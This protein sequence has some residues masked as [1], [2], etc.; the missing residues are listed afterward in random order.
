MISIS[1]G[2]GDAEEAS[3]CGLILFIP[4]WDEKLKDVTQVEAVL[5]WCFNCYLTSLCACGSLSYPK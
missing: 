4:V 1:S 2:T 3:L 5:W